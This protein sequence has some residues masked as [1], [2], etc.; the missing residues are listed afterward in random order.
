MRFSV[1]SCHR[2]HYQIGPA[3]RDLL[4]RRWLGTGSPAPLVQFGMLPPRLHS[5][6]PAARRGRGEQ[7]LDREALEPGPIDGRGGLG[8]AAPHR[9]AYGDGAQGRHGCLSICAAQTTVQLKST[10]TR[11]GRLQ[12]HHAAG[13]PARVQVRPPP[14]PAHQTGKPR[15][16]RLRPQGM[17]EHTTYMR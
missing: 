6:V 11:P 15:A 17:N 10:C 12:V 2:V 9:A 13:H 8:L 16:P 3:Y 5:G 4:R 7:R 1:M 14:V